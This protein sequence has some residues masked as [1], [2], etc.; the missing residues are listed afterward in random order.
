MTFLEKELED[1]VFEM[2]KIGN[3]EEFEIRGFDEFNADA[4]YFRQLAL[5]SYGV[6]DIV[7]FDLELKKDKTLKGSIQ[8]FEL[9]KQDVNKDTFIQALKYVK[10]IKHFLEREHDCKYFSIRFEIILMGTDIDTNNCFIYLPDVF[11]EIKIYSAYFDPLN[12]IK[13]KLHEDYCPTNLVLPNIGDLLKKV[14]KET[15]D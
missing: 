4:T 11:S 7:G 5:G 6:A 15:H 1:F 12:G 14:T 9:K 2:I 8:V 3:E 13:F 10:G